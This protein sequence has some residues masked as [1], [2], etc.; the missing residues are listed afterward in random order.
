MAGEV[1]EQRPMTAGKY[2]NGVATLENNLTVPQIEL[3]HR[4]NI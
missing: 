2:V 3:T 4:V 1:V